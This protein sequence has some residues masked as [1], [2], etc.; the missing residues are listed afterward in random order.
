MINSSGLEAGDQVHVAKKKITT[1]TAVTIR[2]IT[3]TFL[4]R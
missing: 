2:A 4:A 1:M 3:A